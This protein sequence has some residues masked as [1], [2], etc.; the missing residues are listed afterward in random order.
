MEHWNTVII[1]GL[2]I[3]AFILI[4]YLSKQS[5][6]KDIDLDTN[7]QYVVGGRQIG[8]LV[9]LLSMGATFFSTWTLLGAFG[10]YYRSGI[11][12]AGFTVWT[13]F[14]GIFV[15]LFGARIWFI[16]KKYHFITPGQMIEHYYQSK[17]LKVVVAVIG[18]ASLVPVMLIQVSG[19]AKAL[20]TMT[21]GGVPYLYGVLTMALVVGVV[22]LWAGF[23]GTAWTDTFMGF[24]FASILLFTL[25]Y[26]LHITGWGHVFEEAS[27]YQ[28]E[29][30][31]NSGNALKML[32]TWLGLGFGAWVM[33][34]MWQKFYSASSPKVLGKV[35]A[36]TPIW[37]SWIMAV[38][39]LIVAT[40]A[41]IPE[42]VP[43]VNIK[44]SDTILPL[45]YS[46]H[47][48]ILGGIVCAGILAAAMS[49]INS[50]LLSSASIVAE[51][52][53]NSF[54]EKKLDTHG[55]KRVT[56]WVVISLTVLILVLALTPGGTGFLVPVAALGFGL[57]LQL[58]PSALGV[59]YFRTITEKGAFWGIVLGSLVMVGCSILQTTFSATLTGL[60]VNVGTTLLL[61]L[62][63][64]P[65]SHAS[66]ENYHSTFKRL[67]HDNV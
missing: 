59:L 1:V 58:V 38:I 51:D 11:W 27:K 23:K 60:V 2:F 47:F 61:S 65:V 36:M 34:H 28:P 19:G 8:T 6:A 64:K 21:Q 45:F 9:L 5:S 44:N 63:T 13:I 17:R 67:M 35:A 57:G 50:Q 48:P 16:G 56:Q 26:V 55:T 4:A 18:I 24:L 32:E 42:V 25:G 37:N 41:M 7:E 53:W 12:F 62:V 52:I 39:P 15:W 33:P 49:T 31:V 30:M 54:A 22:V 40:A 20:E 3:L 10:S 66:I 46:A 14:H 29:K 43:G